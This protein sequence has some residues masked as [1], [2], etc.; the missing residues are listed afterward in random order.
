MTRKSKR[1]VRQNRVDHTLA[2]YGIESKHL[3]LELATILR[4]RQEAIALERERLQ[5][6][7]ILE[8]KFS[9]LE[10]ESEI[11]LRQIHQLQ[12]ETARTAVERRGLTE[13]LQALAGSND[14]IDEIIERIVEDRNRTKQLADQMLETVTRNEQ[15][16]ESLKK[17]NELYLLQLHQLQEELEHC[18]ENA[19]QSEHQFVQRQL[20]SQSEPRVS[21]IVRKV[22]ALTKFEPSSLFSRAKLSKERLLREQIEI[23][24]MSGLFDEKWYLHKYPEVAQSGSDPIEHYLRYGT[25]EGRNPSAYFDTQWYL[26]ANTDVADAKMNPLVHYIKFGKNEG[27]RPVRF[28]A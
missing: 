13:K 11:Y 5:R 19:R 18:F 6:V 4:A 23:V 27:R 8:N 10:K 16:I 3:Q 21:R 20:D 26:Q 24:R 25:S 17:E 14:S 15:Q 9:S 22:L 2:Q 7:S 1:T 12:E 28:V